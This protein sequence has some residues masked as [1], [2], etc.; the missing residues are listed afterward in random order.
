MF[1][2]IPTTEGEG[3]E[4]PEQ[5][6]ER[7]EAWISLHKCAEYLPQAEEFSVFEFLAAHIHTTQY[8]CDSPQRKVGFVMFIGHVVCAHMGEKSGSPQA[9]FCLLVF[10]WSYLDPLLRYKSEVLVQTATIGE[11]PKG[12]GTKSQIHWAEKCLWFKHT[13]VD[14]KIE[15]R[16]EGCN[17][18]KITIEIKYLPR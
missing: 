11:I 3:Q 15:A 18:F 8:L 12:N 6:G 7:H 17:L 13:F 5:A 10:S 16:K 9:L 1:G 14:D 2:S 4:H